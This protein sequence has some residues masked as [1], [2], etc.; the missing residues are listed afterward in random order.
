MDVAEIFGQ[1]KAGRAQA[2]AD[3]SLEH[4]T[5]LAARG[6]AVFVIE[7]GQIDEAFVAALDHELLG[8]VLE[9]VLAVLAAQLVHNELRELVPTGRSTEEFEPTHSEAPG[10][11][12]V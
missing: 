2:A 6:L 4:F 12:N 7:V 11:W 10:K 5:A 8:V 1:L 9:R 3:E